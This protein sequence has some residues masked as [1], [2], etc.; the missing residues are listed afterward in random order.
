MTTKNETDDFDMN[1]EN[2]LTSLFD[3][4]TTSTSS[5]LLSSEDFL[6]IQQIQQA[7]TDSVRLTAL[8]TDIP[9][10][11]NAVRITQTSDMINLPTNMQAT[12]VI[13]YLKLLPEFCALNEY[14]KLILTKYNTFAL[15]VIRAALNYDPLTDTYHE[16][17]TNDCVF[18]GRDIIDCFSLEQY[19]KMTRCVLS[20]LTASC[21]DRLILQIF[22]IILLFSKGAAICSD[23]DELEPTARDMFPIYHTQNIFVDLLWKYCEN[24]YGYMKTID[25]WLQLT[26]ASIDTHF[27]AFKTRRDFI[28]VDEVAELLSP[29]MKSVMLII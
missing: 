18:N 23:K 16:P 5:A 6:K 10:F 7:Y 12:R 15:V 20:L 22:I 13:T 25:I 3:L 19:E 1:D 14:D 27:Q 21:N 4:P 26:V 24:K 9:S 28:Q 17:N 11:P 8:S 29:L 2:L